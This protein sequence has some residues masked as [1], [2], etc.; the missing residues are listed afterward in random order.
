MKKGLVWLG[1]LLFLGLLLA[2]L[3]L[4]FYDF[5]NRGYTPLGGIGYL[6]LGLGILFNWL[7]FDLYLVPK[8]KQ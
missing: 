7:L 2:L 1:N 6:L 3:V 4:V 5:S 8:W